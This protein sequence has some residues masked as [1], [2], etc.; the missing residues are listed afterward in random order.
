MRKYV[1][2]LITVL[3][4][5][6]CSF[7]QNSSE[8]VQSYIENDRAPAVFSDMES[9]V[10]AAPSVEFLT[11]LGIING[12]DDGTF[13]PDDNITKAEFVK[14]IICAFGLYNPDAYILL[15]DNTPEDWYFTYISSALEKE[16]ITA[17]ENKEFHSNDYITREE[18]F[19]ISKNAIDFAEISFTKTGE[20]I[21]FTDSDKINPQYK[22]AVDYMSSHGIV[23]GNP[24]GTL[25]PQSN[26][27]RAEAAVMLTRMLDSV[28][29]NE[30]QTFDDNN[31]S[32][33]EQNTETTDNMEEKE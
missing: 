13:R 2:I 25:N 33:S 18:M 5:N 6:C 24:D 28:L 30:K 27:T 26:S 4:V 7:A 14:I 20:P 12:F 1:F 11:S 17:D 15:K 32:L 16:I 23:A 3:L 21:D 10:W 8:L 22:D 31:S 9:V 19:S 29:E